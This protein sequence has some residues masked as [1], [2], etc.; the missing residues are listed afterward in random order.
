LLETTLQSRLVVLGPDHPESI[1]TM[2][3]LG[4][5]YLE[6][7]RVADALPLLERAV[8]LGEKLFGRQHPQV[9]ATINN[10]ATAYQRTEQLEKSL[11]LFEQVLEVRT[12]ELGPDHPS[13]L[14]SVH[15]LA[16]GY[17]AAKRIDDVLPLLQILQTK[18]GADHA[19]TITTTSNLAVEHWAAKRVDLAI[20]LFEQLL[21]V[22]ESKFGRYHP[23]TQ[24]TLANL[25]I[26]YHEAGRSEESLPLLEEVLES[27]RTLPDLEWVRTRILDVYAKLKRVDAFFSLASEELESARINLSAGS[28][29]LA[30]VLASLGEQ[31]LLLG[32]TGE[33]IKLLREGFEIRSQQTPLE[34]TASAA[35]SLLGEALLVQAV[36]LDQDRVR[37]KL[38]AEAESLLEAGYEGLLNHQESITP[39]AGPKI[40]AALDR[41]IQ[42]YH[43][44]GREEEWQKYRNLRDA[45]SQPEK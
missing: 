24:H 7:H 1:A 21:Q 17:L 34:W 30:A 23:D 4:R 16:D 35:Q 33:A 19:Y 2:A 6:S 42:L 44:L 32:Q 20:P 27:S 45:F 14:I 31:Y 28:P 10:L 25:G 3:S 9:L 36:S 43:S 41:L 13:T 11:P 38:I 12:A 29:E 22:Q 37:D 8:E 18:L 26:N 40:I 15:N 39:Q 5:G